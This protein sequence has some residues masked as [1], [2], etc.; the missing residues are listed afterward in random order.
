MIRSLLCGSFTV[1]LMSAPTSGAAADE[2]ADAAMNRDVEAIRGLLAEDV[3]VN[4]PG[5]YGTPALHWIVR[6]DDVETAARAL[7]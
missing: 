4:A 1:A 6:Y 5:H 7:T 3:D 2:I